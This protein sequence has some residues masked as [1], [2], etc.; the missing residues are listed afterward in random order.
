MDFT[1]NT[2]K[3]LL[4]TLQEEGYAFQSFENFLQT[5]AQK[6]VILRHDIDKL[7]ENALKM[8]T[9]EHGLG[10][11]ASYYF[12]AV[13]KSFDEEIIRTISTHGHEI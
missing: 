13:P 9:L 4:V 8:A 10:V 7:P 2:Y 3:N 11:A 12:R 1:P 6:A 5:P